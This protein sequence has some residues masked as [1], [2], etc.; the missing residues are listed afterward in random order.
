MSKRPEEL[1]PIIER[2]VG[3]V[4][5]SALQRSGGDYGFVD[6]KRWIAIEEN[7]EAQPGR[8]HHRSCGTSWLPP[9]RDIPWLA[10]ARRDGT[11]VGVHQRS[12]PHEAADCSSGDTA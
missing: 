9:W 10:E 1:E 11:R 3:H 4:V 12:Y 8:F 7:V 2:V 6:V 5:D